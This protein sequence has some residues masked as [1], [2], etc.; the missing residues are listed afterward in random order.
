MTR[1]HHLKTADVERSNRARAKRRAIEE[2]RHLVMIDALHRMRQRTEAVLTDLKNAATLLG[3]PSARGLFHRLMVASGGVHTFH[4]VHAAADFAELVRQEADAPAQE[5]ARLIA[6]PAV[7]LL[8]A[9]ESATRR[10]N[11]KF[12]FRPVVDGTFLPAPVLEQ[13]DRGSIAAVPALVGTSHEEAAAFIDL[14]RSPDLPR[15]DEL[16]HTTPDR[17]IAMERTYL[18]MFPKLSSLECRIQVLTAEE[19][20]IPALRLAE[21]IRQQGEQV[22]MYRFDFGFDGQTDG[23][24][25]HVSDL[26]FWWDQLPS[27]VAS[28]RPGAPELACAMHSALVHFI[29]GE[30]PA[31]TGQWPLYET[32][33]RSTLCWDSTTQVLRDPEGLARELWGGTLP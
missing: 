2:R 1:Q 5:A 10:W 9:Q 12:P 28:R 27:G 26:P 15:S 19:Y 3:V 22:W 18:A 30:S 17:V 23:R 32:R 16:A 13:L 31:L 25:A 33:G 8:A 6:L 11:A 24:P 14:T 7:D 4:G 21:R 29:R 20:W